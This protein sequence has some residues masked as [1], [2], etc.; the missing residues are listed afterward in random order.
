[1]HLSNNRQGS[2]KK[3][4]SLVIGPGGS[5]GAIH[6]GHSGRER[7]RKRK[8]K[9]ARVSAFIG[10]KGGGPRV[11]WVHSLLVNFKNNSRE[12]KIRVS[13]T[14]PYLGQSRLSKMGT[15][16]VGAAWFFI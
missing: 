10:T 11:F 15:S 9:L 2:L 1:M 5:S 12:R 8:R 13:P 4:G 7:E 6:L 16:W 3:Q 14:V